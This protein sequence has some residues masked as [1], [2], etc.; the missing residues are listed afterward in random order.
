VGKIFS[1]WVECLREPYSDYCSGLI[2]VRDGRTKAGPVLTPPTFSARPKLSS[3][4]S[5]KRTKTSAT[6]CGAAWNLGLAESWISGLTS[7]GILDAP[8]RVGGSQR[9]GLFV[10]RSSALQAGQVS[11]PLAP[12][13]QALPRG[14]RGLSRRGASKNR[15]RAPPGG[16]EVTHG[17]LI[18]RVRGVPDPLIG[19]IAEARC[20]FT[21]SRLEWPGDGDELRYEA[22]RHAREELLDGTLKNNR[23][24]VRVRSF[25]PKF[26]RFKTVVWI[27][28]A[29]VPPSGFRPHPRTAH[30]RQFDPGIRLLHHVAALV[31]VHQLAHVHQLGGKLQAA[32]A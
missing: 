4:T 14:R 25:A 19:S 32:E 8:E 31:G 16:H 22:V 7:V 26:P 6:F 30:E 15:G 1:N 2:R 11:P 18:N 12:G 20:Q 10:C 24:T 29:R 5:E 28:E 27:L 13:A 21:L 23:G 9:R 17:V 3:I